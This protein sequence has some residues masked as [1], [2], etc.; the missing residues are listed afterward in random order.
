MSKIAIIGGGA[1]GMI[2][3]LSAAEQGGTVVLLEHNEKLGKKLA[4][5][6]NGKCNLGNALLTKD[7]YRGADPG[8]VDAV[9]EACSPEETRTFLTEHGL[10][11][12]EKRGYFYPRSEQAASVVTFFQSRLQNAGVTVHCSAEVLKVIKDRKGFRVTYKDLLKDAIK[13]E[14]FDAVILATGGL[15]GQNLGAGP[16]GY[17]TAKTFGHVLSPLFPAL[18]QL[19]AKD[20][21]QKTLS[22]VRLDAK[23]TLLNLLNGQSESHTESGEVLFTDY[24]VSGICIMQLSR[25]AGDCV[26]SGGMSTLRFDFF[27]DI[28]EEKMLL[29]LLVR[30]SGAGDMAIEDVLC[31]LLPKK[32][33]YVMLLRAGLHADKKASAVSEA[34]HSA[35]VLIATISSASP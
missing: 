1:S 28:P 17:E 22:G 3:A 18:V 34:C 35:R 26:R 6:G 29:E 8:F 15:S 5:T 30:L 4:A 33:L 31:T 12:K 16:F 23:V 11:L 9:F 14:A 13:K 7:C 2:A 27:P 21:N 20:K 10:M 19:V 25:Y 24:G 32:L